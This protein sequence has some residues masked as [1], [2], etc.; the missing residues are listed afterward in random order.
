[1]NM[2]LYN[3][4]SGILTHQAGI[5]STSNNIAN[6]NTTGYRAN[7]PEFE[8]LFNKSRGYTNPRSPVTNDFGHGVTMSSNAIS[9]KNGSYK[10]TESEFDMAYSGKGW[11]VVGTQK[12]GEFDLKNPKF[13]QVQKNYFTRDGGFTRN[14]EGYLVDANGN[15]LYGIDLGKVSP[16]NVFNATQNPEAD[17]AALAGTKLTPLKIP[18]DLYYQPTATTRA[19]VAVNLNKTSKGT[20]VDTVFRKTDGTFDMDAFL[21]QDVN[22]LMNADQKLLEANIHKD[23]TITRKLAS[24][25]VISDTFTYGGTGEN[26]FKTL[27]ELKKLIEKKTGLTLDVQ[28]DH[29]GNPTGC[30]MDLRNT[31]L[32]DMEFSATGKLAQ[33]LGIGGSTSDYKSGVTNPY[34]KNAANYP[35]GSYVLADNIIYRRK[36]TVGNSDPHT[37]SANWE[38]VD[39]SALEEYNTAS[40]YETDSFVQSNGKVYKR[41]AAAGNSDPALSPA[42]WQEIGESKKGAISTYENGKNYA[43]N[44]VVNLNGTLYRRKGSEGSSNPASDPANWSKI[45]NGLVS[46]TGLY[47][48]SY[49]SS[50]N[51]YSK[52]GTKYLLQSTYYLRDAGV[53]G[54]GERWEVRSAIYDHQGKTMVS[55]APTVHEVTFNNGVATANNV[56]LAFDGRTINYD[57]IRSL[58]GKTSTNFTYAESSIKEGSQDGNAAGRLKGMRIDAHG[59]IMLSFT[60]GRHEVMGRVGLASFINDQG[61]QKVGGNLFQMTSTSYNGGQPTSPSGNPIV[62]WDEAGE[63]KFGKVLHKMIETSNVDI[64]ATLTQLIVLQRGYSFNAKAFTTGDELIKEAIGL[65]R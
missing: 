23:I 36:A 12:N 11:F 31:T 46:T 17:K 3:G 64:G 27:G 25:K 30:V 60:N 58:N 48:P 21:S 34:D 5:D 57:P 42:D 49:K 62:P 55:A 43:I 35:I 26:G 33:K 51:V 61:L 54:V 38:R 63:L 28:R 9:T 20:G 10:Q 65:K 6:V 14:A 29:L 40:V 32:H 15:Y 47:V 16:N 2:T 45:D 53:N 56:N 24:G 41:I 44:D 22:A 4:L 39:T 19:G 52:D 1:M 7:I 13:G 8:T 18:Q 37:D 59:R 50:V